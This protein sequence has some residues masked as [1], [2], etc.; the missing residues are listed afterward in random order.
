[1][2]RQQLRSVLFGAAR[3][4]DFGGSLRSQPRRSEITRRRLQRGD[5]D[6]LTSDAEAVFCDLNKSASPSTPAHT[7]RDAREKRIRFG[8][9][10]VLLLIIAIIAICFGVDWYYGGP[11]ALFVLALLILVLMG[12]L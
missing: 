5:W 2:T 7:C 3:L 10:L 6:L 11:V 8:D 9:V 12:K 1:M 4:L